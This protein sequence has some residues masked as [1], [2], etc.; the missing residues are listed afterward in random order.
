MRSNSRDAIEGA[1]FKPMAG[2]FVFRAPR[3]R[4][5][6]AADRYLVNE[7][8]KAEILQIMAAHQMTPKRARVIA[9]VAGL[10]PL[11]VVTFVAW[12]FGLIDGEPA[13]VDIVVVV[14]V[15]MMLL[16]AAAALV[17]LL[18][19]SHLYARTQLRELRPILA[20][21]PRTGE[22]ITFE[23]DARPRSG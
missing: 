12:A 16:T 23:T 15:G 8:K 6:G 22:R 10:L 4:V 18:F 11:A 21:L 20:A 5:F 9:A 2:G 1:Y 3:P 19:A 13:P 14:T 17:A 7:A